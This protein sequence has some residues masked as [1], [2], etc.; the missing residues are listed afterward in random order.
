MNNKFPEQLLD[1]LEKDFDLNII[2]VEDEWYAY[3]SCRMP[4]DDVPYI[5]VIGFKID[6]PFENLQDTALKMRIKKIISEKVYR[7]FKFPQHLRWFM[8]E[9]K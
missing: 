5:E 9:I 6:F 7:I 8:S 4:Y 3:E 1:M 2:N